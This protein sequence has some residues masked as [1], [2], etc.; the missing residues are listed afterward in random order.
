M[1]QAD[2][3]NTLCVLTGKDFL[4]NAYHAAF[5][6]LSFDTELYEITYKNVSYAGINFPKIKGATQAFNAQ[7]KIIVDIAHNLFSYNSI[8]TATPFEI[9]R[10]GFP[11]LGQVCNAIYIAAGQLKVIIRTDEN[12]KAV[13]ELDSEPYQRTKR[14]YNQLA[15]LVEN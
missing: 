7:Q 11:L 3:Y 4:D 9:S 13:M 5:Y 14:F 8:C 2:R 1:T 12:Q 15:K 10:L 6:L